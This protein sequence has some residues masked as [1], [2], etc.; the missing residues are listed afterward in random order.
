MPINCYR[1]RIIRAL[2]TRNVPS[3]GKIRPYD[4]Q[5]AA[6]GA[7]IESE[8]NPLA[9]LATGTGKS[10]VIGEVCRRVDE[11]VLILVPTRELC[12]QNERA[13]LAVWPQADVGIV[14]SGLGRRDYGARIVIATVHSVFALLR[15]DRLSLIGSRSL[16]IVDEAHRVRPGNVGMFRKIIAALNPGKVMGLT[17]TPYRLD[18]GRLDEGKDRL[19]DEVVFEFGLLEGIAWRGLNGE[20]LLLP[21]IAKRTAA[22]IDVAGVRVR[23]GDF[24]E[25]DLAARANTSA[26][27]EAA[28]LEILRYSAGRLRWLAFCCGVDHAEHV[29]D[30]LARLGV[31]AVAVTCR[32]SPEERRE[33]IA[34]FRE[35]RL[36]CLTGCAVFTTGFDVPAVDLIAFLRPTWSTSLYIQMAGRGT[37]WAAGKANCLV[38]DF[39]RNVAR[40]G[41]VDDPFEDDGEREDPEKERRRRVQEMKAC[42]K[43]ETYLLQTAEV[44]PECGHVFVMEK[45]RPARHEAVAGNLPVMSTEVQWRRVTRMLVAEHLNRVGDASVRIAY[46]TADGTADGTW[47]RK[48]LAFDHPRASFYARRDW[49]RFGGRAPEPRSTAEALR[50]RA[51]IAVPDAICVGHKGRFLDVIA[52]RRAA[53]VAA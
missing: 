43:C 39:A 4:F 35:G 51:E 46:L 16:V 11:R 3:K 2:V 7:L 23:G 32:S 33:A 38:L 21:L 45:P 50:R 27:V 14:C 52:V 41:P 48:W 8:G 20:R 49:R 22:A 26:L 1:A 18:S 36:T 9:V 40:L 31:N 10:V 17:A 47:V 24:V 53:D 44:C 29:A 34:A 42:P 25:A 30:A 5:F 13:L 37:R 15:R 12:E 19:F 28:T 6:A